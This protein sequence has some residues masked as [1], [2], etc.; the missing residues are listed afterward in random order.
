M[1]LGGALFLGISLCFVWGLA[2]FCYRL[3]L[4]TPPVADESDDEDQPEVGQG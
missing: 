4:T 1:T 3:V 2:I